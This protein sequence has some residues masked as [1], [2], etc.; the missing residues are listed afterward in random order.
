MQ[1]LVR[2]ILWSL[3][4]SAAFALALTLMAGCTAPTIR[5][6][7]PDLEE[8]TQV[9]N[10][11]QFVNDLARPVGMRW[12]AVESVGLVVGLAGTGSDPPPSSQRGILLTEMQGRHV[13]NANEVLA[14]P[15]TSLVLV[16]GVLPPGVRK[17]D[18][19]D[20]EVQVPSR[21]KTTSLAGGWLM[22]TRL[23]EMAV[24]NN[25]I[26]TG[27]EL[28]RAEGHVL[29]NALT[30]GDED[31]VWL[32]RGSVLGGGVSLT[33]R[34]LG[35]AVRDD[36]HS[37]VTS[38]RIGTAINERF[39]IYQQ[40]AKRGVATPKRDDF[41]ELAVH[42]R[43]RDNLL[44]Y[45]RV[46]QSIPVRESPP[47]RLARVEQLQRELLVP[48]TSARAAIRLEALDSEGQLALQAG[49]QST[50]EE[51]RFYAAEALA[52]LDNS[53]A[54]PVL[55]AS[56]RDVPAFRW[57]ALKALGAMDEAKAYD[58]LSELL[59]VPSAETRYGAFRA[60]VELGP[61]DPQVAG[62]NLGGV[63]HLHVV[64][65][66]AEP[67]VHITRSQRPEIVLFGGDHRLRPPVL[68]FAGKHTMVKEGSLNELTVRRY[69]TDDA[70]DVTQQCPARLD[71]LIRTLVGLGAS[72][73]DVVQVITQAAKNK[74]L[75]SRVV[76]DAVPELGRKYYRHGDQTEEEEIEGLAESDE[77]W[78]DDGSDSDSPA[79]QG[80]GSAD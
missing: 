51:V 73:P 3:V 11:T 58:E 52:Y 75:S 42:P 14:S 72:Y 53:A 55:S 4:D 6:Q 80:E 10:A 17:G 24:L 48:S 5:S 27:H 22:Q 78:A 61:D 40:G 34:P 37:V 23:R 60:L 12:V 7:S 30:Q 29:V 33:T 39:H 25:R 67:M 35:L 62:K 71:E 36:Y 47:D 68:L 13:E 31:K 57:R 66:P 20:V 43:Y 54:A 70:K 64:S 41:I 2:S 65:S 32:T 18:P 38:S 46:V 21:S 59:H 50:N 69:A 28:A 19:I 76:F 77:P 49:L 44:R 63:L 26:A 1:P 56:A 74:N 45:I 79:S 15:N 8:L 9:S 16:R